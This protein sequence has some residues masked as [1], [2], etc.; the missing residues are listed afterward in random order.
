MKL[1]FLSV[2][3]VL[4][5]IELAEFPSRTSSR[6]LRPIVLLRD[7]RLILKGPKANLSRDC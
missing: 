5:S 4:Y 3:Y 2:E 7:V 1:L 6:C